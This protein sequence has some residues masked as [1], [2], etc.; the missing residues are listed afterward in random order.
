[1][2][3]TLEAPPSK[4]PNFS[5]ESQVLFPPQMQKF[6]R[7]RYMGS[8]FRLL[9]WLHASFSDLEF[10]SCI[11][12]FS[13]SGA[14]SYLL[15]SMGKKVVSNDSLNFPRVLGGALIAKIYT[16]AMANQFK[17]DLKSLQSVLEL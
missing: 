2:E 3:A 5:L 14:V 16:N 17:D 8:K 10:E 1:M 6:P 15:K 9:E 7:F 12:A 11:D 13:G 4:E